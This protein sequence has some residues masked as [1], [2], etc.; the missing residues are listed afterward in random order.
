MN[1]RD[2]IDCLEWD[3]RNANKCGDRSPFVCR[4]DEVV[5]F[6]AKEMPCTAPGDPESFSVSGVA[7]TPGPSSPMLGKS[8]ACVEIKAGALYCELNLSQATAKELIR[9]LIQQLMLAGVFP[10]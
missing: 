7:V 2:Q 8:S 3:A 9:G 4:P 10:F 1:A 5:V 6:C